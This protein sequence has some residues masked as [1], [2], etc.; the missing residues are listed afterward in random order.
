MNFHIISLTM[1]NDN[2]SEKE[3]LQSDYVH[4]DISLFNPT[5][6]QCQTNHY[7]LVFFFFFFFIMDLTEADAQKMLKHNCSYHKMILSAHYSYKQNLPK[8]KIK[9]L[10]TNLYW[11]DRIW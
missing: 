7:M 11:K 2:G 8:I 4:H 10:P 6:S 1:I 9:N 5:K 3:I